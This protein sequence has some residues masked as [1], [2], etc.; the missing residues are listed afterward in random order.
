MS[1]SLDTSVIGLIIFVF[2]I[3]LFVWDKLPMAT[4]AISGCALMV[5]F[6]VCDFATAFGQMASGTVIMLIGVMITGA[7]VSECGLA[8]YISGAVARFGGKGERAFIAGSFAVAF[9]LST[10]LTNVTVLAIFI[11]IVFSLSRSDGAVSPLNTVIPLVLAVNMGGITTLIGSSQQMAAQGLLI[12]YGY[13]GFSVFE[14]LP[15]GLILGAAALLY[16]LF[17][18]YPLGKRIW[19]SRVEN[20]DDAV[21]HKENV[22]LDRKKAVTVGGI[23]ALSVIL[24]IFQGI[25]FTSVTIPAHFT[26]VLS[27]L[28]CIVTGCIGQKKAIQSVNWNIVGRLGGCLGLAKALD[29]SGG[30]ELLSD[31]IGAVIGDGV[32]PFLLFALITLAA[33]LFSLFISNSTAISVTLLVV[34]AMA[35]SLNINVPAF[36][37]GIVLAASMGASCPLSGSTWGMSM[38]VGYKFRDYFKYGAL[39]DLIAYLIILMT[40][41]LFMGLTV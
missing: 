1:P 5:L 30:I 37:M 9:L 7:A 35:P 14:F 29:V 16:C 18:G 26:A 3:A 33:Q 41:P 32:S 4:S 36:A 23:F 15:F 2:C 21:N 12:E 34:M 27:A 24:Y 39:I 25:P 8:S 22:P 20:V 11:P 13:R 10:F 28:A 31:G 6:G 19:G 38:S 17:I 40:V